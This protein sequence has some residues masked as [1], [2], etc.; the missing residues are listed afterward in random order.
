MTITTNLGIFARQDMLKVGQLFKL[1]KMLTL[2]FLFLFP[3]DAHGLAF[4][5]LF[6]SSPED[7]FVCVGGCG[8]S[9]VA[10]A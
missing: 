1:R 2:K 6:C 9:V 8:D 3:P 5:Q 10:W 7:N 4:V